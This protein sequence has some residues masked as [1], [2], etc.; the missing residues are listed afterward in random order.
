[1]GGRVGGGNT[2]IEARGGGDG[3]REVGGETRKEDNI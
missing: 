1:V 3:I 2:L